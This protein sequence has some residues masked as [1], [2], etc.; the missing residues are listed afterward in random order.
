M[1]KKSGYYCRKLNSSRILHILEDPLYFLQQAN[2]R[3][4]ICLINFYNQAVAFIDNCSK[5]I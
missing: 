1:H 4:H 3:I 5:I 2:N